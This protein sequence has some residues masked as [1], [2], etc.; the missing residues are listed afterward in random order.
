[1][2]AIVELSH[3]LPVARGN[4]GNVA[5]DALWCA[6]PDYA[7]DSIQDTARG[8]VFGFIGVYHAFYK[9]ITGRN[10]SGGAFWY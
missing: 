6:L 8:I 3:R 1:M 5:W 10:V 9:T 2:R 7:S 4:L